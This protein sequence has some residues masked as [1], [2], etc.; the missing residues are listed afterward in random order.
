[1]NIDVHAGA[2]VMVFSG[3]IWTIAM[4]ALTGFSIWTALAALF[5]SAGLLLTGFTPTND[6]GEEM[7]DEEYHNE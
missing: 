3:L 2:S 4:G 1:M 7:F 5:M 6:D